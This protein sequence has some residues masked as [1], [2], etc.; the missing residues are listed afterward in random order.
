MKKKKTQA[1]S[2]SPTI[3]K[4][5]DK[6]HVSPNANYSATVSTP[7]TVRTVQK[8]LTPEREST[9]VVRNSNPHRHTLRRQTDKHRKAQRM[10][11]LQCRTC[12]ADGMKRRRFR[13]IPTRN[14]LYC[15]SFIY[16]G[17]EKVLLIC[18]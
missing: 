17:Y 3:S 8:R 4:H 7:P 10:A 9:P 12:R 6:A 13:V 14:R 1:E 5:L 2:Q 18:V 11:R 15:L 16:V